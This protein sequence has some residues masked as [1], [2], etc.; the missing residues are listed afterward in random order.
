MS[1]DQEPDDLCIHEQIPQTCSIC[2]GRDGREAAERAVITARFPARYA[3]T[4][5]C[6]HDVE[7]GDVIARRADETYVCSD[8]AT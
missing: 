5:A 7:I 2:N 6:G 4:L 8:C 3:S 1:I